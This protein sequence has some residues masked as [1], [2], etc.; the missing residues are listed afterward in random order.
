MAE[1]TVFK[2]TNGYLVVEPVVQKEEST[3][4]FV[5]D[6]ARK[7]EEERMGKVL[8]VGGKI[9][10]QSGLVIEPPCKVGDTIVHKQWHSENFV[11]LGKH[12]QFV[13]FNDVAA[14]LSK[15]EE[16]VDLPNKLDVKEF[17]NAR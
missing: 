8:S 9:T 6:S 15:L 4:F 5:A 16:A 2:A 17:E 12:Y 14:V 11:Y 3:A 10:L 7:Y 13:A 1:I